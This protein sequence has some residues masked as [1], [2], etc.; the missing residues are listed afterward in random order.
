MDTYL[1]ASITFLQSLQRAGAAPQE[2][3]QQ[4]DRQIGNLRIQF[5]SIEGDATSAAAAL[6]LLVGQ[7]VFDGA[8]VT[9]IRELIQV[10]VGATSVHATKDTKKQTNTYLY[11]YAPEWL[12][13]ML[14]NATGDAACNAWVDVLHQLGIRFMDPETTKIAVATTLVARNTATS[15]T[16]AYKLYKDM[17]TINKR[18]RD[19]RKDQPLTLRLFPELVS[20]FV[21]M[22]PSIYGD[23]PPVECRV[24]TQLIKD[25]L[26]YIA[27]RD[28]NVLVA[29]RETP[30]SMRREN[31]RA[32]AMLPSSDDPMSRCF[33][34]L[35]DRLGA[36][37][38]GVAQQPPMLANR[39]FDRQPTIRL[40]SSQVGRDDRITEELESVGGQE[41]ASN[42]AIVP[43]GHQSLP[44]VP[45]EGQTPS[46][47]V[48]PPDSKVQAAADI[49][50]MLAG[51]KPAGNA[52][53]APAGQKKS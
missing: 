19:S 4:A 48:P 51:G 47:Q 26:P 6:D 5:T 39:G 37:V 33:G 52:G 23:T 38:Q 42:H 22:Y 45:P 24:D 30:L 17:R 2:V 28:N 15:P 46:A 49:D 18:R 32:Q 12:W 43:F 20:D 1:R 50:I 44:L 3:H 21:A 8:Q 36:M 31:T 53:K 27:C 34:M 10:G 16:V 35:M 11:N 9:S 29:S 25:M 41:H 7:Q 14:P 13:Q 40:G